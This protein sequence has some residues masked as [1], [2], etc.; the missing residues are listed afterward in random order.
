V[1][2]EPV[3]Y[4]DWII[5]LDWE[6][7]YDLGTS[8]PQLEAT[9]ERLGLSAE[10][11]VING[12]NA[13]GYEKLR[14]HLAS[15]YDVSTENVLLSQGASMANFLLC[16]VL[17]QP[18]DEVV[19]ERPAYEPLFRIPQLLGAT[20]RRVERR[21]ENGFLIDPADLRRVLTKRTRLIVLSNLHN[22]S[23]ALLKDDV[24][25]QVGELADS[26]DASVL[27]DEIYLEF[28]CQ[29]TPPSA[30][31]LGEPFVTTNSLTKVY[32]LGGL[33]IG[34]A[35]CPPELVRRAQRLY[36]IMGVHHP[37]CSEVFGH[38]IL[39]RREVWERWS[40]AVRRR[41]A[42]NRPMLDEFFSSREDLEWV[43]PAGG[44]IAFPRIRGSLTA[45]KLAEHLRRR[46]DTFIIPGRFF[47]DDRHF[48]LAWGAARPIF[49]QG[50]IHLAM[51]LDELGELEQ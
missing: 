50:L 9:P 35:L 37:I 43:E 6:P 41:M 48:R 11:I 32:G 8:E 3:E 34:W 42:E 13:L 47:E 19:V 24:L 33:R 49:Q 21:F 38:L 22:P 14:E 44:L 40:Q 27:V 51:A 36:F 20:I 17:I 12:P 1:K 7:R 26:V 18:G 29:Q 23:G 2:F 16:A 28:L 46:F 10:D 15:R 31:H 39:S 4:L 45:A 30:F 5:H 25:R